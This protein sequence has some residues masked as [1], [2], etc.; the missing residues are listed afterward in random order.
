ML[1]CR[2][3]PCLDV[4]DGRVVKGIRFK[5]LRDAG[6]PVE[7]ADLYAQQG[8]DE[9]VI[10]DVS[11]TPEGRSAAIDTV[12]SV[13]SVLPIPLT[14]GGGV[15][16]LDD[17]L[18]MLDAGADK[19]AVNSA[20]VN[21][22]ELI[23]E[24]AS[25]VGQ[26]C[27]V[28]AIDATR[29]ANAEGRWDVV[30]RSGTNRTELDAASWASKCVSF[31]AGEILLTSFDEDGVG[32]GYDLDL[33]RKIAN[34]IE[35]PIVASGG[36]SNAAHMVDALKAGASAVLAASI[37]HDGASTVGEIKRELQKYGQEVRL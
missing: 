10:L 14:V 5:G 3:I 33:I 26:Q 11:A 23:A 13:R 27:V 36:A 18:R 19:I 24:I 8:A 9:V 6:D 31:G 12:S 37:F 1:A 15:R 22:P 25:R 30:T 16:S 34:T 35:V 17:A 7:R 29:S 21:R 20:A 2:V 4:N 28:L 32:Q